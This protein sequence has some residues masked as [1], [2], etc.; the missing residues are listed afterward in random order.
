MSSCRF[1]Y[2]AGGSPDGA[3]PLRARVL[4][5][6]FCPRQKGT[7]ER[8]KGLALGNPTRGFPL[9][10]SRGLGKLSWHTA[11]SS[12]FPPRRRHKCSEYIKYSL[13]FVPC[14]TEKSLSIRRP[15]RT[16]LGPGWGKRPIPSYPCGAIGRSPAGGIPPPAT[17]TG[18]P[19]GGG[20]LEQSLV[21]IWPA[22]LVAKRLV[23]HRS[24]EHRI[25]PTERRASARRQT[26]PGAPR[27]RVVP[28]RRLCLES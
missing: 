19:P 4:R 12:P 11:W 23:P 3:L 15:P 13:R 2:P 8:P 22:G 1:A 5:T 6:T 21:S 17:P 10:L 24:G 20:G 25:R 16:P 27:L 18:P 28:E 14:W 9:D 7:K 26:L